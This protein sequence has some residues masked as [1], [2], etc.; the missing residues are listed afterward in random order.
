PYPA[1]HDRAQLLRA[2]STGAIAAPQRAGQV[3]DL[4]MQMLHP[5]PRQRP[6]A[7]AVR[8]LLAQIMCVPPGA[9]RRRRA[10][11][12]AVIVLGALALIGGLIAALVTLGHAIQP[13]TPLGAAQPS[14]RIELEGTWK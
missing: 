14:A 11:L 12:I 8:D 2:A 13:D 7:A 9:P 6:S 10:T 1:A 4:L 5:E 3:S